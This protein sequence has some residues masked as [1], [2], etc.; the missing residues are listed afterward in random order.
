MRLHQFSQDGLKNLLCA[1]ALAFNSSRKTYVSN[2]VKYHQDDRQKPVAYIYIMSM[3]LMKLVM[4]WVRYTK[5]WQASA[6]I[7]VNGKR[8][9]RGLVMDLRIR[10]LMYYVLGCPV[11][12]DL[13]EEQKYVRRKKK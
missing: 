13:V 10:A 11:F 7:T 9:N 2:I 1:C 6:S 5:I 4:L 12:F 3:L 8:M